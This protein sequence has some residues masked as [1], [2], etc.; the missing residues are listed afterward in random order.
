[1]VR[2]SIS[3]LCS[4]DRWSLPSVFYSVWWHCKR[5]F[6]CDEF[7]CLSLALVDAV[8][9]AVW[10]CWSSNLLTLL[11]FI[12]RNFTS[13]FS[14]TISLLPF[15]QLLHLSA[16][17]FFGLFSL[18]PKNVITTL[19]FLYYLTRFFLFLPTHTDTQT[20]TLPPHIIR[21][22]PNL[23]SHGIFRWVMYWRPAT[24]RFL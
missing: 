12:L 6:A 23:F 11:F 14:K 13:P 22:K 5:L 1:M 24:H 10:V 3:S 7:G 4:N 20:H 19:T 21:H 16:Q 18:A 17:L 8:A 9:V 15:F 2:N